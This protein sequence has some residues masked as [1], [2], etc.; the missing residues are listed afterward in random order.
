M[1]AA[2]KFKTGNFLDDM[3]LGWE[4]FKRR[5]LKL[6]PQRIKENKEVKKLFQQATERGDK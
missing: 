1:I 3:E 5:K 6:L 2:Y 4:M